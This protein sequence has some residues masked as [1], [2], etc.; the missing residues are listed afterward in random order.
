MQVVD[1][2]EVVSQKDVKALIHTGV[3]NGYHMEIIEAVERV[4]EKQKS[5]VYEKAC[6]FN[7]R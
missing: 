1:M 6:S 7:I 4:N 2:V 3:E 5:I